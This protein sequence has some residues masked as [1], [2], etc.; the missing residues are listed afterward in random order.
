MTEILVTWKLNQSIDPNK[1]N[2][3]LNPLYLSIRA[4]QNI[5]FDNILDNN[6]TIWH[7]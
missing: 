5:N 1:Y 2:N 7:N 6:R 3:N 4:N